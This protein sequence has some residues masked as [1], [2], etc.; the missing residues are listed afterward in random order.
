MI[1]RI[2]NMV[3][4]TRNYTLTGIIIATLIVIVTLTSTRV[5]V[6]VSIADLPVA[7]Y[8]VLDEIV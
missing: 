2:P 1:G 6:K 5:T 8:E 3:T 7:V 4:R